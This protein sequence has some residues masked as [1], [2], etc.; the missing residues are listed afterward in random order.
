M[1]APK[2]CG[3]KKQI[4]KKASKKRIENKGGI[5]KLKGS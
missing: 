3:R 2:A 1:D 5:Q 4:K